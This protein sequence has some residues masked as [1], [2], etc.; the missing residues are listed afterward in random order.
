MQSIIKAIA[1]L[2]FIA[3]S[4]YFAEGQAK[5]F[6]MF[7]ILIFQLELDI[8]YSITLRKKKVKQIYILNQKICMYVE[9]ERNTKKE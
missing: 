3:L 9:K 4:V 5:D 8:I 2:I 6:G 7:F 1:F